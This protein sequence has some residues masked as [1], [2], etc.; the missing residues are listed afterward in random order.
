MSFEIADIFAVFFTFDVD[1]KLQ[2]R[3]P[4]VQLNHFSTK[5][6]FTLDLIPTGGI[7]PFQIQQNNTVNYDFLVAE[8]STGLLRVELLHHTSIS[9]AK[10]YNFPS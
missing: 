4:T 10:Q 6:T 3:I 5:S 7:N 9:E 1:K 8:G 2:T